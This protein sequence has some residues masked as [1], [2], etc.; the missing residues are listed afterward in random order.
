MED[1]ITNARK[2]WKFARTGRG[3]FRAIPGVFRAKSGKTGNNP[4]QNRNFRNYPRDMRFPETG[5]FFAS[6]RARGRARARG[7]PGNS[8]AGP[9]RA[10]G[11]AEAGASPAFLGNFAAAPCGPGVFRVNSRRWHRHGAKRYKFHSGRAKH[12]G[13]VGKF[14]GVFCGAGLRWRGAGVAGQGQ[15]CRVPPVKN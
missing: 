1:V 2:T 13:Q 6:S 14:H 15:R 10:P 7:A 3:N 11:F 5:E 8:G 9:G 4:I 12:G